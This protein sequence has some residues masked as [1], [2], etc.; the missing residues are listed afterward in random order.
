MKTKLIAY[1]DREIRENKLKKHK[2]VITDVARKGFFVE[3]KETHAQGFVPLRT[4]PRHESYRIAPNGISI[5]ARNPKKNLRL[6]QT[7]LVSIDKINHSDKQLDF[8]LA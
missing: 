7:V 6:G 2:A 5:V 4:L 3:L 8:R 1:Y